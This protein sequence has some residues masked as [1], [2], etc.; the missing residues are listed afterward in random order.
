MPVSHCKPLLL[1]A[2][3]ALSQAAVQAEQL[4]LKNLCSGP[5]ADPLPPLRPNHPP[6]A[7]MASQPKQHPF[8]FFTAASRQALRER[9]QA[10]P[11]RSI[12]KRLR[13]HA[14]AC[15]KRE[16]PKA[17]A[18]SPVPAR[19]PDGSMNPAYLR[20]ATLNEFPFQSY[21]I[22]EV[23]PTLGFAFQLTGDARFG[24]AGKKWLL[25][26]S[27]RSQFAAT[28]GEAD[29]TASN[30]AYGMA[31]GY[32]WLWELMDDAE[33]KQVRETLIRI[34]Q[35]IAASAK[36]YLAEP[37][38]ELLGGRF[39]NNHMTRTHGLFGLAALALL[40]EVPEARTWL[41]DEIQLHRDRLF[42]SAW[43]PNGE[44]IDAWDHF[45]A[46]LGDP[47][48][49]MVALKRL[50]GEDLFNDPHLVGRF[51][52]IPRFNIFGL[53]ND[54]RS[55][56]SAAYTHSW[57]A[58]AAE[59]KHPLAQWLG[60]R[61][62]GLRSVNDVFGYLFYDPSV[63]AKDPHEPGSIYWPYS[64]MVKMC[65]DWSAEGILVPFRCGPQIG[66]DFGDQNGFRMRARG[67]WLLPRLGEQRPVAG[68]PKAFLYD[69]V[70]W[71]QGSAGQNTILTAPEKIGDLDSY[72]KTNQLELKGGIQISK[73]L[74][75][76]KGYVDGHYDQWLSGPEIRKNGELRVVHLDAALD[77]V[78]GEA[79]R[80]YCL[81]PPSLWVRQLLFVKDASYVV[82]C[83]ELESAEQPMTFAWQLHSAFPFSLR[84]GRRS[85][86]S[87]ESRLDLHLLSPGDGMVLEKLTPAPLAERR[88]PFLQWRTAGP[89][90]RCA[91]VAVLALQP[92]A[93]TS[94]PLTARSIEAEG[95]WGVEIV[96]D[97]IH[98]RAIF[99][100]EHA[101]VVTA[102]G[103]HTTG[104][105]VLQRT[106]AGQPEMT[107]VLGEPRR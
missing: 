51:Q 20:N 26:L 84:D 81:S 107:Y 106:R 37:Q 58:L 60:T 16:I 8:L 68:Q 1:L 77:Y 78:C 2:A 14:E 100:A 83:D 87:H 19:L 44:H 96:G 7:A 43:A 71:F 74:E 48:P 25:E 55:H 22:K 46:S 23:L 31:L 99:R 82:I 91:Y 50:G 102:G 105:A 65:S 52:S 79:H 17:S 103:L 56:A 104:T 32:D 54:D 76:P 67:E 41:D 15:L 53:E 6:A 29:F 11:F 72:Q 73:F 86:E 35:P 28:G 101:R 70:R 47:I 40:Y 97:G 30:T 98:D 24:A 93:S 27:A 61:E 80:A 21:A 13:A 36:K 45:D 75:V 64:G 69:L 57:L 4:T 9:A 92:K 89:Q 10:E 42:P 38:P 12:E 62:A 3:L 94:A 63:P 34:A 88:T 33:R 59:L 85:I 39:G 95:G 90:Q 5:P 18:P 66:K 49:F